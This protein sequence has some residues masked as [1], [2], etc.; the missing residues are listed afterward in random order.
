MADLVRVVYRKYDGTLHWNLT[1][2]RLGEDA[3]GV[4]LGAPPYTPIAKGHE[5]A[6]PAAWAYVS[7]VPREPD[8]W[9]TA[10]FNAQPKSTEIYVDVTT[11]ARWTSAAEVGCVDLD[12]D[13]VR[14]RGADG[15][16]LLD[17][18]EFAEHRVRY[19]YPPEVVQRARAAADWLLAAVAERREP[20]GEAYRGWLARVG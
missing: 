17:E 16:L 2:R 10:T 18:D 1:M 3:H 4:W 12:L 5:S 15:A 6:E 13:V 19:G 7:L 20:F 11:P 8:T 14:R 9:W